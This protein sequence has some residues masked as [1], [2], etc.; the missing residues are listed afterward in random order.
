MS[1]FNDCLTAEGRRLFASMIKGSRITFTKIVMGDGIMNAGDS[2]YDMKSVITPRCTL[3]IESVSKMKDNSVYIKAT[4]KNTDA[5]S[6][7]FREKGVYAT[8][9][10]ENEYLVFYANNGAYAE[11]IEK[12]TSQIIEKVIRTIVTFSDSD[13]INITI[14]NSDSG[15]QTIQTNYITIEEFAKNN[16]VDVGTT[17]ILKNG[18]IYIF[19]GEKYVP[20]NGSRFIQ[21]TESTYVPV[22]ERGNGNLYGFVTD[23]RGLIVETFDRY[24]PGTEDPMVEHTLYGIEST[25]RTALEEDTNPYAGIFSNIV[26]IEARENIERQPGMIY[27]MNKEEVE[28]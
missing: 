12:G 25:E 13:R 17:V 10:G 21:M 20:V 16:D 2:E 5:A 19:N 4:F 28:E 1:S 18:D 24:V 26:Y 27:A 3:P 23:K 14:K 8:I 9:D 6:F 15:S 7:Y 11:W 22:A